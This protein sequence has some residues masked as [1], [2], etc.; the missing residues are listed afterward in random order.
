Q[1]SDSG[2]WALVSGI[3]E[4]GEEPAH[5][6]VREIKEETGVDAVVDGL[7]AVMALEPT[8]DPN[9]D[10]SQYLDPISGC[11]AAGGEARRGAAAAIAVGRFAV[12]DIPEGTGHHTE[13][14]LAEVA[15]F[16]ANPAAGARFA[17]P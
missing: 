16:R 13:E 12:D 10:R 15:A 11:R 17:R 7:A 4:P 8:Q 2:R 9:G 5:A 14:R 3:L 6:M 1:R